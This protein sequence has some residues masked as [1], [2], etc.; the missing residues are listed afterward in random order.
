[1]VVFGALPAA[2][3]LS[4]PITVQEALYPGSTPGVN[5]T[6]E[7][8]CQGIPVAD[9]A[10]INGTNSL[11]LT[12]AA[13]GQFRILGRWPSGNAKWIEVCG[14]LPSLAAGGTAIVTLTDAGTGNFGG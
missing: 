3:A 9:S 7:P 10:G 2:V 6:N 4:V 11:G 5:R 13:A 1:L 14:I 8:F 12:G